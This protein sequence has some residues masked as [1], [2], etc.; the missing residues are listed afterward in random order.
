MDR[1]EGDA[2]TVGLP[3][4]VPHRVVPVLGAVDRD[5]HAA[6]LGRWTCCSWDAPCLSTSIVVRSHA[7]RPGSS[8]EA[9][10]DFRLL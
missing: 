5:D 7:R 1:V 3:S 9:G 2:E 6:A 4:R 10:Q 8:V